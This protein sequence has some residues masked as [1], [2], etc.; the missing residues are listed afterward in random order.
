MAGEG[1]NTVVNG[2]VSLL[3][4]GKNNPNLALQQGNQQIAI[5]EAQARAAAANREKNMQTIKIVGLSLLVVVVI[6]LG[7]WL[8]IKNTKS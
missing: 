1:F 8:I 2:L 4:F 6:V 3:S 7:L 5:I